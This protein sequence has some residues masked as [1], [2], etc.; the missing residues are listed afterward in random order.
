[1]GEIDLSQLDSSCF[2]GSYKELVELIGHEHTL[3]LYRQYAGQ[4]L[5]FP[6]KLLTDEFLH[7]QILKEYDGANGKQL[8][9][10]YGFTYS[11]V[12]KI[13]RANKENSDR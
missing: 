7:G 10:K 4:Y 3:L 13:I 11:W 2:N 8:A 5:T 9:K 12:M 6:K 1:M